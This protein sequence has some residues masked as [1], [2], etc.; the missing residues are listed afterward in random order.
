MPTPPSILT[1]PVFVLPNVLSVVFV[2]LAVSE[3]LRTSRSVVPSTSKFVDISTEALIST[4]LPNVD[5]PDTFKVVASIPPFASISPVN[6]ELPLTEKV[7][8]NTPPL[9]VDTPR[10]SN[11][12]VG[13]VLPI[14]TR[15]LLKS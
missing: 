3:T 7:S 4:L 2:K 10:T 14:P 9:N 1:A 8:T 11:S 6:I 13:C 15:L 12:C 5:S